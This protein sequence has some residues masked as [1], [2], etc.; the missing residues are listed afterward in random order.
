MKLNKK[1]PEALSWT[2]DIKILLGSF[3]GYWESPLSAFIL[4]SASTN[5][6]NIS[7]YKACLQEIATQ[8]GPTTRTHENAV[9]ALEQMQ[10]A[11]SGMGP[12]SQIRLAGK[13]HLSAVYLEGNRM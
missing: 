5:R 6:T 2:S 7:K 11:G 13:R 12:E 9:R 1:R 3:K 10:V 8:D 4:H